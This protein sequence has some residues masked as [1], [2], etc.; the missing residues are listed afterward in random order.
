[1]FQSDEVANSNAMELEGL[2]RC[3]Q[4]LTEDNIEVSHITTDRHPQ[5]KKF[6]REKYPE[7][8]R[9]WFDVWHVAKGR[10]KEEYTL[11]NCIID[12]IFMHMCHGLV[13]FCNN[14]NVYTKL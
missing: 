11:G 10:F 9:H 3:L 8:R 1:M 7:I 4:N 6:I 2:K 13:G 14:E 5:V 12:T